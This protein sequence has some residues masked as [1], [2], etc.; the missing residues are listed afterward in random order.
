MIELVQKSDCLLWVCCVCKYLMF[1]LLF[2]C[3]V[4][5]GEMLNVADAYAHPSFFSGIDEMTGFKTRYV[6]YDFV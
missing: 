5:L 6:L 1:S 2:V 4:L 3:F